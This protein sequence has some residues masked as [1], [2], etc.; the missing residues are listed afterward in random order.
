MYVLFEQDI[1]AWK[2]WRRCQCYILNKNRKVQTT[3]NFWSNRII[4]TRKNHDFRINWL[5]IWLWYHAN[6][7]YK[8]WNLFNA[9]YESLNI[10]VN[11]RNNICSTFRL[12][13]YLIKI[14]RTRGIAKNSHIFTVTSFIYFHFNNAARRETVHFITSL[15][16]EEISRGF[17][18]RPR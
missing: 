17:I 7:A 3:F 16:T 10:K 1:I 8:R 9:A 4:S 6:I 13:C 2:Y 5:P 18:I 12:H 14:L 15:H 11:W